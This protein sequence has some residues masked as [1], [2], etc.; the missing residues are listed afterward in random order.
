MIKNILKSISGAGRRLFVN[1]RLLLVFL[2]FYAALL[3]AVYG[4][5][6]T[7]EASVSQ[8][9]LTLLLGLLAPVLFFMIQAMAVAYAG[10]DSKASGLVRLSLR[11]FWKL[12]LMTVPI[13]LLAWLILYLLGRL[14]PEAP[15][16]AR[17]IGR[18]LAPSGR[19]PARA[20]AQP[21]QWRE[22]FVA[23]ARYLL[24][25]VVLPLA[26]VHLWIG[27]ASDGFGKSLKRIGRTLIRAFRP[28]S[29]LIYAGGAVLFA[30]VPWLL[31]V[32]RTSSKSP[33]FELG[34]LGVRLVAAAAL[35]LFGWLLT[36]GALRLNSGES[37]SD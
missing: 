34:L 4:F 30:V 15:A 19:S 1:W 25:G 23:A 7:R 9:L 24:L 10:E 8:L 32:T 35:L 2:L 3:A 28:S 29:V 22:V 17:E 6:A 5:I 31:V 11:N 26:A 36:I 37:A 27:A 18:V 20:A 13:I 12:A 16:A 33:W 14:E 21:I